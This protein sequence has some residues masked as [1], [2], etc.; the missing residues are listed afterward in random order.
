M[1]VWVGGLGR[2]GGLR[3]EEDHGR[4]T[5]LDAAY[6]NSRATA[7][8]IE[9]VCGTNKPIPALQQVMPPL[10][11]SAPSRLPLLPPTSALYF[12]TRPPAPALGQVGRGAGEART[13]P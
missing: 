5:V 2:G 9:G 7:S 6:R 3:P 10:P 1:G 8:I 4:N 12:G 13:G 11:P